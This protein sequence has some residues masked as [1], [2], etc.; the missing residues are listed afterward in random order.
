[1][2][3]REQ[4][5]F[6]NKIYGVGH[7]YCLLVVGKNRHNYKKKKKIIL[8]RTIQAFYSLSPNIPF[9]RFFWNSQ[10]I[11]CFHLLLFTLKQ[12]KRYCARH[13]YSYYIISS[14]HQITKPSN[15]RCKGSPLCSDGYVTMAS[16]T[17]RTQMRYLSWKL[18]LGC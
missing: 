3:G 10:V 11:N 4:D 9:Y 7:F 18:G 16:T 2:A 1:M 13:I 6:Q 14:S 12:C 17:A 8:T 5:L 15:R